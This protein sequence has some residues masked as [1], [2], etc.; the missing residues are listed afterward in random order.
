MCA[1]WSW[2]AILLYRSYGPALVHALRRTSHLVERAHDS[3]LTTPDDEAV[4]RGLLASGS[5]RSL[6]LGM[7]L[8]G[9]MSS[10]AIA[11]ELGALADDPRPDVRMA[12]LGGLAAAGDEHA[13]RR[14]ADEVLTAVAA[15]DPGTR[16]RAAHLLGMLEPDDRAAAR[17][18]FLDDD[19][20]VRC[21]ALDAVQPGDAAA[22]EPAIAALGD[23]GSIGAAAGAVG[24]LGDAVIPA[25]AAA[26]DRAGVPADPR[27][28]RLVR[29]AA[30]ASPGRDEVLRRFVAHP[31]RELGLVIIER[32]A[33]PA[34]APDETAALLEAVLAADVR[35]AEAVVAAI[36]AFDGDGAGDGA[37]P[38]G[39]MPVRRALADE[40]DLVRVRIRAALLARHGSARLGSALVELSAGGP[41]RALAREAL[42]VVVGPAQARIILPVLDPES[43]PSTRPARV[44]GVLRD[45]VEDAEG[46]WRSS[47]LRACALHAARARGAVDEIDLSAARALGDPIVDEELQR[48]GV[49]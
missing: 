3:W 44:D 8:L 6:R 10:P 11:A 2:G 42:E 7:D 12:A 27:V 24:R 15:S 29:A 21:A 35:H 25:L 22:V 5:A 41:N 37:G 31:D 26:L 46:H 32:L 43:G 36:G 39:D 9:A 34:P 40:L 18:L 45:L 4:A 1:A 38:V 14:L 23:P 47:W 20:A 48:S 16:V 28:L 17:A 30:T 13:R 19:Q 49:A 33:G